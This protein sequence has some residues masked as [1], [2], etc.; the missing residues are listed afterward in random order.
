MASRAILLRADSQSSAR[1]W[2]RLDNGKTASLG[3]EKLVTGLFVVAGRILICGR[4]VWCSLGNITS[5]DPIRSRLMRCLTCSGVPAVQ[6]SAHHE[7]VSS[8]MLC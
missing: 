1:N 6:G 4:Q 7:N 8:N 5:F 2:L 3:E